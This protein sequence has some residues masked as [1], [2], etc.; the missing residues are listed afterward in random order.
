MPQTL[1]LAKLSSDLCIKILLN[2]NFKN[3]FNF[4]LLSTINLNLKLNFRLDFIH[5]APQLKSWAYIRWFEWENVFSRSLIQV[6]GAVKMHK[7]VLLSNH[8]DNLHH[9]SPYQHSLFRRTRTQSVEQ[10]CSWVSLC[11]LLWSI[12][13]SL[14]VRKLRKVRK[15][16]KKIFSVISPFFLQTPFFPKF[17]L[18]S[19]NQGASRN[20]WFC[21]W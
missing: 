7:I 4:R 2:Q 17:R 12:Q 1:R 6:S 18:D 10:N 19:Y 15:V 13:Q 9:F 5:H 20:S 11:V 16:Q 8:L 3:Y 21:Q 14:E